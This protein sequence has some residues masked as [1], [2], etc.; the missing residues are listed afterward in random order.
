MPLVVVAIALSFAL[1]ALSAANT[2]T[3]PRLGRAARTISA[4]DLGLV[5]CG[6]LGLNNVVV[7]GSGGNGN[8][9]VIGTAGADTLTG[10][11]GTD[12]ILAGGGN[13]SVGGGNGPNDACHGGAGIDSYQP[14]INHGCET[15]IEIP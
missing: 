15:S 10:G 4:N 1:S 12:C 2:V 3:A 6:N 14:I 9:L 7:G 8:D 11:N 13:D 5:M